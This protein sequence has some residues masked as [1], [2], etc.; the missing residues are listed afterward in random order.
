MVAECARTTLTSILLPNEN[1]EGPQVIVITSPCPGD[2]KTTVLCNLSIAVAE[3]GR[4]VLLV[5]GDLL[6]PRLN[7]VVGVGNNWG[8]RDVLRA[9]DMLE[10]IPVSQLVRETE[11]SGLYLLP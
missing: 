3:V 10:D 8:V 4:K 7:S 5:E 6:R 9:A 2:G 1:G 11:V